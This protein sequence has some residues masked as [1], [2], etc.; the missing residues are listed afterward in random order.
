MKAFGDL[1]R[2][3]AQLKG[4]ITQKAELAVGPTEAFMAVM[5][6]AQADSHR[7]IEHKEVDWVE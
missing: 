2:L 5:R 6:A 3:Q 4:E 7:L 1:V